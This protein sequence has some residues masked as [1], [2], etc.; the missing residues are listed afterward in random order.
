M[1]FKKNEKHLITYPNGPYSCQ[2]DFLVVRQEDRKYAQDCKVIP[3]E[4]AAKQNCMLIMSINLNGQKE[5][6]ETACISR[7]G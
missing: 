3:G 5:K 6:A 4:S 7:S 1:F 2:I